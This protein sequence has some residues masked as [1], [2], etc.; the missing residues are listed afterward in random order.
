MRNNFE[1]D[2]KL[3]DGKA[4]SKVCF[5]IDNPKNK[6]IENSHTINNNTNDNTINNNGNDLSNVNN[7]NINKNDN[8]IKLIGNF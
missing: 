6:I 4:T 1:K 7:K 2:I 3:F 5:N 8:N